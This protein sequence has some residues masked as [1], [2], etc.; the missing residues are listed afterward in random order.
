MNIQFISPV[1]ELQPSSETLMVAAQGDCNAAVPG[2]FPAVRLFNWR[3][4]SR[5]YINE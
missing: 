1:G 2:N 3:L 4:D 5:L